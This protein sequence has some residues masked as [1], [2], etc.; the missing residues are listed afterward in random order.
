MKE[1]ALFVGIDVSQDRLDLAV[2]P[3]GETRQVVHDP[4]GT[5]AMTEYLKE[6]GPQLVVVVATGG[7]ETAVTAELAAEGLPVVVANPRKVRA[8]A[9]ATGQLAKT[10]RWTPRCWRNTGKPCGPSRGRCPTPRPGN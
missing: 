5:G 7:L 6:L 1:V 3:T 10:A 8:F 4:A 2:R 9:R